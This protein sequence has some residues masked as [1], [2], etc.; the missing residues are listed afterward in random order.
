[1]PE[2]VFVECNAKY[3]PFSYDMDESLNE[4]QNEMK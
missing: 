3:F 2:Q 4:R 1:M